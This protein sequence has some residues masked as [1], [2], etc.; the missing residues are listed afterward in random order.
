[1][2][3]KLQDRALVQS[4]IDE[5]FEKTPDIEVTITGLAL[6]LDISKFTLYAYR[7]EGDFKD[8]ISKAI[9]KVEN[10]YERSLRKNG[11]AGD[12]FALKN[13]GWSDKQEIEHKASDF[14]EIIN[15]IAGNTRGLPNKEQP[16]LPK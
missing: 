5:Y 6:A 8:I 14:K 9:S 10:S 13:F 15:T 3:A 2:P 7:K 11:K 12:I 16:K 4:I 1:M